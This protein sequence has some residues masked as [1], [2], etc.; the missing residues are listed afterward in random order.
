MQNSGEIANFTVLSPQQALLEEQLRHAL[1]NGE[2]YLHY[3]PQYN[4]RLGKV[5]AFEA[6]LRWQNSI[7]GAIAPA[8]FIK[9]AEITGL[10]IPI[11]E[12]VLRTACRFIRKIHGEGFTDCRITVNVS[13]VQLLQADFVSRVLTILREAN[14]GSGYL[15]LELTES[16]SLGLSPVL[17]ETLKL[18]QAWD[19]RIALDDFGTGYASLS[20]LNQLKI[21]T[22]KIDK[23]FIDGILDRK[24]SVVLTKSIIHIGQQLGLRVI[25]EGVTNQLQADCMA[26]WGCEL[27]QGYFY[28]RPVTEQEAVV[29]LKNELCQLR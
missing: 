9:I 15:E 14:L 20:R 12:W 8:T 10:I 19:I 4:T 3:Q 27:I 6:L 22:L 5:E 11:G 13:I 7:L 29:M 21:D 28:S 26:E 24:A 2:L 25:A 23:S 16:L 1:A 17:D 18:L